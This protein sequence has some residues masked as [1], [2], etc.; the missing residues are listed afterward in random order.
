MTTRPLCLIFTLALATVGAACAKTTG[1]AGAT[2]KT[3]DVCPFASV[4]PNDPKPTAK[5]ESDCRALV[6]RGSAC[7]T[8]LG[9]LEA[10]FRA[11]GKGAC[12]AD[13]TADKDRC[14]RERGVFDSACFKEDSSKGDAG[15]STD[16]R[17]GPSEDHDLLCSVDSEG[18]GQTTCSCGL[19]GSS[20]APR[21]S[22]DGS[23]C[24]CPLPDGGTHTF[25][26]AS[27]CTDPAATHARECGS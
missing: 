21:L 4:C 22:C 25:A 16:D 17:P 7:K 12:A 8:A 9:K 5:D 20:T 11:L 27:G 13:G 10:C 2:V 6:A 18:D 23:Q 3:P 26:Q 1:D 24:K 14:P 19:A 15:P